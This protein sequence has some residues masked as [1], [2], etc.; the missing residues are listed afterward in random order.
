M[1]GRG[2]QRAGPASRRARR[3]GTRCAYTPG[4]ERRALGSEATSIFLKVRF[5][6]SVCV[7]ADLFDKHKISSEAGQDSRYAV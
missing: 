5:V 3:L 1:P 7:G 4:G 2:D 6:P